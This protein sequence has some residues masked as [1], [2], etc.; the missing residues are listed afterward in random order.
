[1]ILASIGSIVQTPCA[2][3]IWP[4]RPP[5]PRSDRMSP[6]CATGRDR[7][8]EADESRAVARRALDRGEG[9][10]DI[11]RVLAGR[12]SDRLHDGDAESHDLAPWRR[13]S[14]DIFAELKPCR[15]ARSRRSS[16]FPWA[17]REPSQRNG[18]SGEGQRHPHP[19]ANPVRLRLF[20][21][22][23]VGH[24]DDLAIVQFDQKQVRSVAHP[25]I[26]GGGGANPSAAQSA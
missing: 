12:V 23:A 26:A 24:V 16:R 15:R 17:R 3:R 4:R 13:W 21:K 22:H 11:A 19:L 7:F 10:R 8:P 5:A 14:A 6:A 9:I 25:L 2:R 1:V 18:T 20:V